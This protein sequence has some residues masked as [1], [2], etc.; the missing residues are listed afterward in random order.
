MAETT[1]DI[2]HGLKAGFKNGATYAYLLEVRSATP[3]A[4]SRESVEATHFES[5]DQYK[6]FIAGLKETGSAKLSMAW[7]PAANDTILVEF[8]KK[9]TELRIL[10]PSG[11][12]ALDMKG[13][14]ENYEPGEMTPGGDLT[15][16]I[17]FKVTGAATFTTVTGGA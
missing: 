2:G 4:W 12:V 14:V 1:A 10:M 8:N 15:A 17:T 11:T 13:F 16:N 3:P 5:P 6:E 9:K 7:K